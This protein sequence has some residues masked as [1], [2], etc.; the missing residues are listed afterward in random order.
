[1]EDVSKFKTRSN[2]H[3]PLKKKFSSNSRDGE[4]IE[5]EQLKD[6]A[7]FIMENLFGVNLQNKNEED[8]NLNDLNQIK[9]ENKKQ[10]KFDK[11]K[12]GLAN[13]LNNAKR[14]NKK[15]RIDLRTLDSDYENQNEK[16]KEK[17]GDYI[18]NKSINKSPKDVKFLLAK[19]VNGNGANINLGYN[20]VNNTRKF[21]PE[22][23]NNLKKFNSNVSLKK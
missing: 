14:I 12:R 5:N 22:V 3:M 6:F 20:T 13:D 9:V 7:D 17:E 11:N 23:E 1:M 16:E 4:E 8:S 15:L 2:S 21:L 19:N 10:N 18:F